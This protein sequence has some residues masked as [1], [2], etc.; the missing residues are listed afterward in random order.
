[1]EEEL[2]RLLPPTAVVGRNLIWLEEVGSTNTYAKTL[3]QSGAEDGTVVI[4][5]GQ[6]AGRGRRER[7]FQSPKGRGL[8]LTALLRPNLPPERLMVTTALA[9]VAVCGAEDGTVVIADGQTAGR[10]RRERAFQSP[11]GRGLYLTA[12]LRPNLPPERLMVTT[13]LAGVAVCQAVEETCG[14]RPGLKWPN[15]PVLHGKKLCGILTELTGNGEL[16]LPGLKWPN[17]PVL[18]GKKLC[19]ILTELTG[20]GELVLGIGVNVSQTAADFSPE[21]AALA[22]SLE[23]ELGRPVSRAA[24]AAA[25]IAALDRMYSALRAGEME[26]YLAAYRRD[27]V[28][29]NKQ[30]QLLGRDGRETVTAIEIDEL[31][32]LVVRDADGAVRTVRSGEVSV[33]GMYGYVP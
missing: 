12:L 16:V 14:L 7:A 26:P 6:T 24:L 29:L 10:G 27:C 22:T 1:M 17:D 15:D 25:L 4:A 8:Y 33:R 20:N 3:A 23:Q 19:G 5:D 21:V 31:F 11:K 28:N 30:V 18:H 13:A 32:G 2:R 9:G